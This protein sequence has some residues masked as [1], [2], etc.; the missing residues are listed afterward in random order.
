MTSTE[1]VI[2]LFCFCSVKLEGHCT[3]DTHE[4]WVMN[5]YRGSRVTEIGSRPMRLSSGNR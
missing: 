2:G 1:D 5:V 3:D 4:L